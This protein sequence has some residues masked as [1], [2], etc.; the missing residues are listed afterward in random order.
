MI[1]MLA[2]TFRVIGRVDKF[3]ISPGSKTQ[4]VGFSVETS[5]FVFSR[6]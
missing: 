5:S 4:K 1:K 2:N 3:G 6:K